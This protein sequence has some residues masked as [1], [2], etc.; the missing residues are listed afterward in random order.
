MIEG[1]VLMMKLLPGKFIMVIR[2]LKESFD[3]WQDSFGEA[4]GLLG[5]LIAALENP[6]VAWRN[7]LHTADERLLQ[8]WKTSME[9]A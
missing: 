9:S 8:K 5:E 6:R 7:L 3:L 4:D 2:S 1:L